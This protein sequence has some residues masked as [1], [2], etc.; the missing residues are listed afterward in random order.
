MTRLFIPKSRA[1]TYLICT[2]M[3][4]AQFFQSSAKFVLREKI[5][6]IRTVMLAF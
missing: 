5:K 6:T 1:A 3:E 2:N 4:V